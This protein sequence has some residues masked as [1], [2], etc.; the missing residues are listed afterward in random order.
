[1]VVDSPLTCRFLQINGRFC[2]NKLDDAKA[3]PASFTFCVR[4]NSIRAVTRLTGAS[5]KAVSRLLAEA[6]QP[7]LGIRIAPQSD[8]Q[9]HPRSMKS[10]RSSTRSK[11]TSQRRKPRRPT[12]GALFRARSRRCGGSRLVLGAAIEP[13]SGMSA[14][15]GSCGPQRDA[16]F[17]PNRTSSQNRSSLRSSIRGNCR[18]V[19][20]PD[21]CGAPGRALQGC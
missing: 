13:I 16:A 7:P 18:C 1:M 19:L 12:P 9:A 21:W 5:K 15:G 6:G 17:D 2:R 10:G 8:L 20:V 4:A 3:A 14:A 11:R